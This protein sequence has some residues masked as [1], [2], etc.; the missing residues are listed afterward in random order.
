MKMRAI[1]CF[2]YLHNIVSDFYET[3]HILN[4]NIIF[5][6]DK[7]ICVRNDRYRDVKK[8]LNESCVIQ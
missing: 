6:R 4:R 7:T 2:R 1:L 8:S 5:I 3:S